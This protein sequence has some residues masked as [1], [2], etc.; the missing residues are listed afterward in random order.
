MRLPSTRLLREISGPLLALPSLPANLQRL[1]VLLDRLD[2]TVNTLA[3]V[4]EPLQG[5]PNGSA[6]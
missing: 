5:P 6:A 3:L 2:G 1:L 4:A